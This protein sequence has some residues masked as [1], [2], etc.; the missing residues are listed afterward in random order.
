MINEVYPQYIIL[1]TYQPPTNFPFSFFPPNK[2]YVSFLE[3][4]FSLFRAFSG[5]VYDKR[6]PSIS[7]IAKVLPQQ[8]WVHISACSS[9][10]HFVLKRGNCPGDNGLG[11]KP[12]YP[13]HCVAR[14]MIRQSALL[15]T[16]ICFVWFFFLNFFFWGCWVCLMFCVEYFCKSLM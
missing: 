5:Y 6:P 8:V 9:V 1:Y 10:R 3:G 13:P 14:M 7:I 11:D 16:F 2:H 12:W 15:G 4:R